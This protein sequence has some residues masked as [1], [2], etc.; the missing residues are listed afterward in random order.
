MFSLALPLFLTACDSDEGTFPA[1]VPGTP[2]GG[3]ED[4]SAPEDDESDEDDDGG[5]VSVVGGTTDSRSAQPPPSPGGCNEDSG[6]TYAG[7]APATYGIQ[8]RRV[9]LLG[10]VGTDDHDLI[11]ID[12]LSDSSEVILTAELSDLAGELH[13]PP[14]GTYTGVALQVFSTRT[15]LDLSLPD[16]EASEVPVRGW[17]SDNGDIQP[18]D[19]TVEIDGIEHWVAMTDLTTIPAQTAADIE[20]AEGDTGFNVEIGLGAG[21]DPPEDRLTLWADES[22]WSADPIELSSEDGSKDYR[23][24]LDGGSVTIEDGTDLTIALLFDISA[25]LGWWEGGEPDGAFSLSEDCGLR[26]G[27]PSIEVSV[28]QE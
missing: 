16:V 12:D 13:R 14:A 20:D 26:V 24:E 21:E 7:G 10:D 25:V 27:P 4:L 8:V 18:R 22:F 5:S 6:G 2:A 9:T 19:I 23:M 1:V 17:F 11:L 3:G 15:D 28:T